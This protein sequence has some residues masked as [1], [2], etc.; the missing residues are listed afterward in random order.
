[1]ATTQL[2]LPEQSPDQPTKVE[3]TTGAAVRVTAA[4][5]TYEAEQVLPQLMP[6]GLLVI[7]PVPTP[8][9]E[10]FRV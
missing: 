1:M 7:V 3:S 2:P 10:M 4:S 8:V 9:L 5:E 6:A